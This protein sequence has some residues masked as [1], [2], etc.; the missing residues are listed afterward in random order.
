MTI[1]LPMTQ[2]KEVFGS[3]LI[4]N[5]PL[6]KYTSARIGGPADAM[7]VVKSADELAETVTLLWELEAPLKILGGGSNVL[8][9]DAGVRAVVVLNKA[10]KVVFDLQGDP[11]TVTA[12]SG[13][14]FGAVA[15]QAAQ[16]DLSGLEWAAGI[17]GTVGGAVVSNA[18]AHGGDVSSS[19]EVA[20]I[21]QR[22]EGRQSWSVD[23]FAYRYRGS[24]LKGGSKDAVVLLATFRLSR[25]KPAVIQERLDAYLGRR[26]R[27]QPPG[28]SMGSM[29]KNPSNDYAG[30][31]IEAAGLK[32][33]RRGDAEISSV[34]AN[35]FINHGS[36]SAQDVYSLIEQARE[37]VKDQFGVALEL[38]IELFGDWEEPFE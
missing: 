23:Q 22:D 29:F 37:S 16:K 4:E 25:E 13:S 11:P 26:K 3:R 9:S 24:A 6:A 21:L 17:P 14:N 1:T 33:T 34:H 15:R 31:L 18:G 7:I 20:E 19:L 10:R 8:V 28:A 36:A 12:E 5:E 35:F 2:L 30:R 32:G 38:E 27:T